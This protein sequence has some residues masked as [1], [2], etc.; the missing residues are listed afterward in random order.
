MKTKL[1]NVT[2]T[3]EVELARWARIE[4][5]RHEMSVSRFLAAL[6]KKER[7]DKD[8]YNAAMK[9]ALG[10]RAFPKSDGKYL[11]REEAH[12]RPGLR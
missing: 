4:A 9:R 1:R 2:V 7:E 11:S 6:L 12:D 8:Q 10:R 5:A 3:L